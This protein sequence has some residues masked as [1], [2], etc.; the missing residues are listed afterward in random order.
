MAEVEA[1]MMT[2]EAEQAA[3][4]L[5]RLTDLEMAALRK[6][7]EEEEEAQVRAEEEALRGFQR[8]AALKR[9]EADAQRRVQ[10]SLAEKEEARAQ[11]AQMRAVAEQEEAECQNAD[12]HSAV[13]PT[14]LDVRVDLSNMLHVADDISQRVEIRHDESHDHAS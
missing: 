4:I 2:R 3:T 1:E 8:D 14:G 12:A 10:A 13:P 11:A 5:K 9:A 7:Q 6:Q